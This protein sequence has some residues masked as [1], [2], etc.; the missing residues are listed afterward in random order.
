MKRQ[1]DEKTPS[2]TIVPI[3]SLVKVKD[4]LVA[5]LAATITLQNLVVVVVIEKEE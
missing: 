1:L 2:T 3:N 4:G 5:V